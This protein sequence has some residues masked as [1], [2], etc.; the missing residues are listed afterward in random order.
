MRKLTV[1]IEM[2]EKAREMF[3]PMF[4]EVQ[5]YEVLETLKVNFE[6][7]IVVDLIEFHLKED[8]PINE[9]KSLGFWEILSVLKSEGNNHICLVRNLH[10]EETKEDFKDFEL[11]LIYTTPII[12]SLDRYTCSV[13]G[14]QENLAKFIKIME[15]TFGKIENMIFQKGAYQRHDI[16]SI[17]TEKQKEIL[18]T[19]NKFGYYDYPKKINSEQL[20][21]KVNISKAT[22]VQHLRKGE[23]RLM[24]NIFG[25]YTL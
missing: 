9:L 2:N 13:I 25:G 22:L 5:S 14:D 10:S 12:M 7:G 18:I 3:E 6:D 4:K 20:A 21:K 19:A 23:G 17:L 1:E 24:E 11:D 16:I 8:L 15:T